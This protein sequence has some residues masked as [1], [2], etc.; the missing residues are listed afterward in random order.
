MLAN[1]FLAAGK[2]AAG[3][4]G[5]SYAL[6]ADAVESGADIFSSLIVWRALVVAAE[7]P[8]A[9]HPYWHGKAEPIAAA[10]VAGVLLLAAF[11]IA[12]QAVREIL[13]FR[14]APAP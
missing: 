1:A 7:P 12:S 4:Y 14:E 13:S 5:N 3:I 11:G 6:V 10:L 8:D 9:D 2:L